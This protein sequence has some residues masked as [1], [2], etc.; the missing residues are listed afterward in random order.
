MYISYYTLNYSQFSPE[1]FDF[2]GT[3][4]YWYCLKSSFPW[5]FLIRRKKPHAISIKNDRERRPRVQTFWWHSSKVLVSSSPIWTKGEDIVKL[6]WGQAAGA[7]WGRPTP[8]PN[9]LKNVEEFC[10]NPIEPTLAGSRLS[11]VKIL[12]TSLARSGILGYTN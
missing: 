7:F 12:K 10:V 5:Q 1:K 3:P 9:G 4:S 6:R 11:L 8:F 2:F